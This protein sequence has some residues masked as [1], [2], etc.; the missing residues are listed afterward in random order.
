M[1]TRFYRKFTNRQNNIMKKNS[2]KSAVNGSE[3]DNK[4]AFRKAGELIG[5]I[6][7]HAVIVKDNVVGF[8]SDEVKVAS[9]AVKKAVKKIT[10]KKSVQKAKPKRAIKKAVKKTAKKA[11]LKKAPKKALKKSAKKAPAKKK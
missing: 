7:A 2:T 1:I 11:S 5:S 3:S 8:V 10:R 6:A 9:K 4:S